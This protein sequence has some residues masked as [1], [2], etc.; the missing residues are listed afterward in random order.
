M[1]LEQKKSAAQSWFRELRDAICAEFE[2]IEDEYAASEA[3]VR[4]ASARAASVS[5]ARGSGSGGTGAPRAEGTTKFARSPWERAEG[6]GGEMSLMKGRVFEKVGVNISTVHGEFSEPFRKEIPGATDDPRFWASGIS[7]VAHMVSPRVPAVHMNTRM[8]VVGDGKKVWFGGGADLN[9][10]GVANE[11]DN[12]AFHQ[13]LRAA[14]D[15]TD[16]SYFEKFKKWC[17]DYFWIRHR[18]EPRGAGGIFYDYLETD[19]DKN[20]AFTQSVGRTFLDSYPAIVRRRMNEKWSEAERTRQ[21]EK[22]GRYAEF[23]LLY[24]RGTRFGLMTGG[25][26]EAILMSLP[27]VACWP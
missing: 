2:R 16:V 11:A 17:D 26:P 4:S 25:N 24:D 14:C 9:P 19:W 22:R 18:N 15:A 23:N 21:L 3:G 20:F 27:P 10:T 13:A 12:A 6:G 1:D 8:I 5:E 7:L